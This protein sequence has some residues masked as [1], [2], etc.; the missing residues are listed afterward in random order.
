MIRP[1]M[2]LQE[3]KNEKS[4]LLN[5]IDRVISLHRVSF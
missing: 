5:L 2:I 1:Q 3:Q 4:I